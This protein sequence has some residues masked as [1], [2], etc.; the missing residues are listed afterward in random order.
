MNRHWLLFVPVIVLL[1][2]CSNNPTGLKKEQVP[3]VQNSDENYKAALQQQM[4][5]LNSMNSKAEQARAKVREQ[6]IKQTSVEQ[7]GYR[8]S[9]GGWQ[10]YD[11]NDVS[12]LYGSWYLNTD[13]FHFNVVIDKDNLIFRE[14]VNGIPRN[15]FDGSYTLYMDR[16]EMRGDAVFKVSLANRKIYTLNGKAFQKN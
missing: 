2:S 4:R 1:V 15:I 16:I 8:K 6:E 12:W 3:E 7:Q 14:I 5:G 11:I 9:S 10:G 13:G